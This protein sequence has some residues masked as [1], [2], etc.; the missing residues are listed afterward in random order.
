MTFI[1][2]M[3]DNYPWMLTS[4]RTPIID[5][6]EL[7]ARLKSSATYDRR[8]EVL[9]IDDFRHGLSGWLTAAL[10]ADN[11][12]KVSADHSYHTGY[13]ILITSKKNGVALTTMTR[14]LAPPA[15]NKW[16]VEVALAFLTPW[17]WFNL[18]FERYTGTRQYKC[19]VQLDVPNSAINIINSVGAWEKVATLP[20]IDYNPPTYFPFKIVGD[21]DNNEYVRLLFGSN[22]YDLSG[23]AF[24]S[25][26]SAINLQNRIYLT[27]T[28]RAASTDQVHVGYVIVTANEP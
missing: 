16:G 15:L 28:A 23:N 11:S 2:D 22:E 24:S 9:W 27:F 26:V 25:A 12:I 4:E 8:G 10:G 18:Q 1:P 3:P 20:T 21:F 7:A 19:S 5:I 6:G 13:S 17:K 14:T